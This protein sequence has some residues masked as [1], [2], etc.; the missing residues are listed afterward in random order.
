MPDV[1]VDG[2]RLVYDVHGDGEPVVLVAG[3]GQPAVSWQFSILPP[4][5]DAGYRVVTYDNR[6]VAPSDAPPAPYSVADMTRDLAGLMDALELGPSRVVGYSLGSWIVETLAVE[7]PDLVRAA[8]FVAGFNRS[9]AWERVEA[10]AGRDIAS[11]APDGAAVPTSVDV[12]DLLK[13]LPNDALQDD[14]VVTTW[15]SV[16]ADQ[17]PWPNPGRLGQWEAAVAWTNDATRAT[18]WPSI[19]APSLVLVFEHDLD[20]AP[21]HAR[22]AAASLPDGRVVEL[23]GLSHLGVFEDA[24]AVAHTLLEFFA[25]T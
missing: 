15:A 16:F 20:C 12:A 23:P 4:L 19:A 8:A 11:L 25:A 7:R 18:R 22:D 1:T 17:E 3:L 10:D 13:Y 9:S 5:V 24:A 6:G 21:S 14:E 2:V